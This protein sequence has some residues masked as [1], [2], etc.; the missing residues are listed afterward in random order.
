MR[1]RLLNASSGGGGVVADGSMQLA[2]QCPLDTRVRLYCPWLSPVCPPSMRAP[3]LDAEAAARVAIAATSKLPPWSLF[4]T[5]A[6]LDDVR[7]EARLAGRL[8]ATAAHK[9]LTLFPC[10]ALAMRDPLPMAA[11][12]AARVRVPIPTLVMCLTRP[13]KWPP[14]T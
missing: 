5:R 10:W 12:S 7:T 13:P 1:R 2:R 4:G 3:V 14:V 6:E 11:P 9:F 8:N